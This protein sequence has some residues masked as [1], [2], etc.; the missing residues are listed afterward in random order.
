MHMPKG[1]SKTY[2]LD[3]EQT[4]IQILTQFSKLHLYSC[5]DRIIQRKEEI[6]D[7]I[8]IS[9]ICIRLTSYAISTIDQK[10]LSSTTKYIIKKCIDEA[11][12][13]KS[14]IGTEG[15]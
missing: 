3:Q 9:L 7:I 1:M 2:V 15:N 5:L 10:L 4:Q 14:M 11:F 12:L 13:T 6:R 8:G